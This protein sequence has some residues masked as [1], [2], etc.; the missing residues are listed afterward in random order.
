MPENP[1]KK[2]V[3]II[4]CKCHVFQIILGSQR[5]RNLKNVCGGGLFGL[6]YSKNLIIMGFDLESSDKL[7][8]KKM[9]DN[10]PTGKLSK[11][12]GSQVALL[13]VG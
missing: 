2:F 4:K 11:K 8:F 10:F 1:L 3:N 7:N 9:Q 6:M 12:F 5:L 13:I